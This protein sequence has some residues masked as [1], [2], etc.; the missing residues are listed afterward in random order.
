[1]IFDG[2]G[3]I[4]NKNNKFIIFEGVAY[5]KGTTILDDSQQLNFA[6]RLAKH[7]YKVKINDIDDIIIQLKD[8]YDSL[9]LY[10]TN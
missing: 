6:V 3:N 2:I 7:G 4:N 5:K 8:R 10:T 1:M 9:F